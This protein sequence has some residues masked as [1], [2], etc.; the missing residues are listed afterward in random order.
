V[1]DVENGCWIWGVARR[2]QWE[3]MTGIIAF[4]KIHVPVPSLVALGKATLLSGLDLA[5]SR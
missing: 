2:L 1:F 4:L 3:E 5:V